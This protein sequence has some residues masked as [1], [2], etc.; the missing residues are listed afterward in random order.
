MNYLTCTEGGSDKFYEIILKGND[1]NIRYGKSGSDGVSSIKSFN[2]DAEAIAFY[3]KT[4]NEKIKKGYVASGATSA[5]S[6]AKP[7]AKASSAPVSAPATEPTGESGLSSYL[8][9]QEGNSDKF[10]EISCEGLSVAMRYGKNGTEV[11]A[12]FF[13]QLSLHHF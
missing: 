2:S 5:P 1:V 10:Y 11:S 13:E 4:V 6:A 12:D 9:C 8:V 7:K 3:I